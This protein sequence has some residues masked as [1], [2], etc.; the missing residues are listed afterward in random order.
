MTTDMRKCVRLLLRNSGLMDS[1]AIIKLSLLQNPPLK[2]QRNNFS[3][4]STLY[5]LKYFTPTTTIYI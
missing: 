1:F 2:K 5:K 3:F 4:T